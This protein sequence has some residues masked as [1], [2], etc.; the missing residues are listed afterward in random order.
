MYISTLLFIWFSV[1]QNIQE[2]LLMFNLR[3]WVLKFTVLRQPSSWTKHENTSYLLALNISSSK[4]ELSPNNGV[5]AVA[6]SLSGLLGGFFLW[7]FG[8]NQDGSPLLLVWVEERRRPCGVTGAPVWPVGGSDVG[9][10]S[11]NMQN[12]VKI[13]D[14]LLNYS[15]NR[16]KIST[17][18]ALF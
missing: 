13:H 10:K 8:S 14:I 17:K 18:M 11:E 2:F 4:E 15:L 7:L 16:L 5:A 9:I 6:I 3:K 12:I 1:C